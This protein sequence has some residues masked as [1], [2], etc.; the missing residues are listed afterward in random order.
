[1]CLDPCKMRVFE[2]T[3]GLIMS[4]SM[5]GEKNPCKIKEET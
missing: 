5:I 4:L 3:P 1:M 2:L